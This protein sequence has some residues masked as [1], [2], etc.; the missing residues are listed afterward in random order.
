MLCC[1]M[2]PVADHDLHRVYV[3]LA[4]QDLL[5]PVSQLLSL[6][7]NLAQLQALL[8]HILELPA[9]PPSLSGIASGTRRQG[10]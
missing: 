8:G 1:V 5:P 10:Q 6:R 3:V 9:C 2:Q 7:S 4:L